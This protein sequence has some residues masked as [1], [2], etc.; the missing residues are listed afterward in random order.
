[1]NVQKCADTEPAFVR[2]AGFE[3]AL[4]GMLN[5]HASLVNYWK[6]TVTLRKCM[7]HAHMWER[8][9]VTIVR[10]FRAIQPW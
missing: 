6:P 4:D 8:F 2:I 9:E 10:L 3:F 1:M 5:V 7:Y